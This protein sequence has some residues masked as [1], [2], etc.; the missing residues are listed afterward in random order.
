MKLTDGVRGHCY[1][2][3]RNLLNK[4]QFLLVQNILPFPLCLTTLYRSFR[5]QIR[6]S[7]TWK[8]LL[9]SPNPGGLL[10]HSEHPHILCAGMLSCFLRFSHENTSWVKTATISH[11]AVALAPHP[12]PGTRGC[13]C[14]QM[15]LSR[16]QVML[17]A[18]GGK[19]GQ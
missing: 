16:H 15:F 9:S 12:T 2:F 19:P 4:M 8:T 11:T 17:G 10:T 13:S 5:S 14:R 3:P 1:L 6:C 18:A 7:P